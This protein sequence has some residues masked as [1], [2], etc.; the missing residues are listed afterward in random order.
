MQGERTYPTC[1]QAGSLF[2][3]YGIRLVP[4]AASLCVFHSHANRTCQT[5]KQ[6]SC[7]FY[8]SA[9]TY[10]RLLACDFPPFLPFPLSGVSDFSDLV[11]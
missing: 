1:K 6:A 9:Q 3:F 8:T 7:L 4:Q 5:R 10:H 2:Y 11:G